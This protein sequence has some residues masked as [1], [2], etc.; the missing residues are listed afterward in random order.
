MPASGIAAK[1]SQAATF[2]PKMVN[3]DSAPSTTLATASGLMAR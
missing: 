1:N 2:D 3:M